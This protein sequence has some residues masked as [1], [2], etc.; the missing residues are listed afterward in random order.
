M[1]P[2]CGWLYVDGILENVRPFHL[3]MRSNAKL[4]PVLQNQLAFIED[5]SATHLPCGGLNNPIQMA[6]N[7]YY[8][9]HRGVVP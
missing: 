6:R 1:V 7:R 8:P 2:C 5:D 4:S 9:S 3:L